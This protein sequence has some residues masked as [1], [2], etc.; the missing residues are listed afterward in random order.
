MALTTHP[1]TSMSTERAHEAGRGRNATSPEQVPPRG[2][3]DILLRAGGQIAE[4]RV[5]MVAAGVTF[6]MLLALVP[7]LTAFVSLYGLFT[8]PATV[9]EHV[10]LLSSV[11]PAGGISIIDDQLTRLTEQGAPALGLTLLFSLVVALWSASGA[12]K[13]LF[14]AM[15]I[16]FEE[17]EKRNFFVLS[18]LGLLFTL[19]GLVAAIVMLG[20]VIVMP[21]MLGMLGFGKGF[22]WLVQG[23][24]YLLL[25]GLLFLAIAGLYRFGPSREPARWRWVTPGAVLALVVILIVSLLFSWYAANLAHYDKTYGSLGALIGLLTWMWISVMVV[26]VGA[27]LDAEIEHQTA[28]D[29]TT[30]RE[31]PLGLREA[32]MA[33]TV[34]KTTGAGEADDFEDE[35]PD[36]KAGYEAAMRRRL[37]RPG[38]RLAANYIV[39]AA[40]AVL[41]AERCFGSRRAR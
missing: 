13:S 6:F 18:G 16:A 22:D 4:D 9:R 15:N 31:L 12:V 36:W 37:R 17:T 3:K 7:A 27:E 19:A 38:P 10:S 5:P 28:R 11:V 34:G 33:D 40:L 41:W 30:G 24:G 2:W 21:L 8:D 1:M 25:A 29:S 14:D 32:T 20:V 26:I 39:P 35:S 23:I